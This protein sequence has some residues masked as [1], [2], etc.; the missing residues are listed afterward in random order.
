MLKIAQK[1]IVFK[2]SFQEELCK[3]FV[4]NIG[5]NGWQ[6]EVALLRSMQRFIDRLFIILLI[7]CFVCSWYFEYQM[8]GHNWST[9][10]AKERL[11]Y[12]ACHLVQKCNFSFIFMLGSVKHFKLST[13]LQVVY[14]YW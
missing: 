10:S 14:F 7:L 3:I 8:L 12:N 5:C 9:T 6:I 1:L 11:T 13:Y 4:E 2:E